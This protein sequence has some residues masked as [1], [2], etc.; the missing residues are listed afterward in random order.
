MSTQPI[1]PSQYQLDHIKDLSVRTIR[2]L[3]EQQTA[4]DLHPHVD[5]GLCTEAE[6]W[7]ILNGEQMWQRITQL[8][9]QIDTFPL[10]RRA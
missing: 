7:R 2:A 6:A 4:S 5:D 8:Q 10:H 1:P 9:Q 3:D